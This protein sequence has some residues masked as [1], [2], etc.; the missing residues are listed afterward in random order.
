MSARFG[1]R[2]LPQFSATHAPKHTHCFVFFSNSTKIHIKAELLVFRNGTGAS[3][4][5]TSSGIFKSLISASC[6]VAFEIK[7]KSFLAVQP[8]LPVPVETLGAIP[9][10]D[11]HN[12]AKLQFFFCFFI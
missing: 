9:V 11:S 5:G 6:T 3:N 1:R 7:G 12:L 4:F 2:V 8:H 10:K